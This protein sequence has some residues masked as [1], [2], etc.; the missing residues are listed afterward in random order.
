MKKSAI[1]EMIIEAVIESQLLELDS[2]IEALDLLFENRTHELWKE[3]N[4]G[5]VIA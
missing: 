5:G 3:N 1:Y 2:K 4:E